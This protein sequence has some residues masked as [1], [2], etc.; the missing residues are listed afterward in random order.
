MSISPLKKYTTKL[1]IAGVLLAI[2]SSFG[3]Y[4]WPNLV[5]PLWFILLLFVT[6][7]QWL[8]FAFVVKFGQHKTQTLLKQYQVAKYAKLFIYLVALSI[9]VFTVKEKS[10]VFAFLIS[11][12]AY[13]LVFTV[14]EAMSFHRWM[15]KLP[16]TKQYNQDKLKQSPPPVSPENEK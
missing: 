4:F 1:I 6:A 16:T 15:N 7:V 8:V 13:Y 10:L 2:A 11:F 5:H 12:I 9:Y 14:L 3:Q